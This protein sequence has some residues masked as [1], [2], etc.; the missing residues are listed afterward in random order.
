MASR[1]HI[2]VV[3]DEPSVLEVIQATL[4]ECYRVS[5][6]GTVGDA[7][8]F[9]STSEVDLVLVDWGLPDGHGD[10]VATYAEKHS[11]AAIVMSGYASGMDELKNNRWPYLMK[12][13]SLETLS[14]I[15]SSVL[16]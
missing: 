14:A 2:L 6:A 7:C 3:E 11:V 15:V 10:A 12:P 16:E 1:Q 5:G 13:L 9:L 8:T 4:G